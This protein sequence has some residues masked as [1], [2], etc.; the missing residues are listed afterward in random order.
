[1]LQE[2]L[3]SVVVGS[4][5]GDACLTLNGRYWRLRFDH[6]QK[7]QAYVEWKYQML[8]S[9]AASPPRQIAVYDKRFGKTYHH[10][11]F[12]T[13][14]IPEF[15]WYAQQF[16]THGKKQVPSS[17]DELLTTPLA[18]A[19]WYMDD[20]HRRKD[21]KALRLNTHAFTC[22]ELERLVS[23]LKTNLNVQ[24]RLHRV[25]GTQWVIY[26]PAREAQK[27]CDIIRSYIHPLMEYKLL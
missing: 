20:G 4:L 18:F 12:D 5:L 17:I 24:A 25:V 6:G 16:Y 19:V 26:I 2:P 22:D 15:A 3:H 21:C 27:F 23:V 10:V 8:V 11:R 1:M 9:V 7:E 14:S 13:K